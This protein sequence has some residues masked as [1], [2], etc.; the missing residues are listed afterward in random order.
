MFT[1]AMRLFWR[2]YAPTFSRDERDRS[3]AERTSIVAAAEISSAARQKKARRRT[4]DGLPVHSFRTLMADLATATRARVR[5]GDHA[6]D[7]LAPLTALQ[8]RAFQLLEVPWR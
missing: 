2:G 3:A 4:G 8:E 7:Q 1:C 5:V 6:F